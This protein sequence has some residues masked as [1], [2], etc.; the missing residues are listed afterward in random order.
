MRNEL[1]IT[2]GARVS[3]GLKWEVEEGNQ[4]PLVEDDGYNYMTQE[5]ADGA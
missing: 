3:M 4:A 1:Q 5:N 2:Q